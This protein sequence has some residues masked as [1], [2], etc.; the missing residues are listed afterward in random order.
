MSAA[1]LYTRYD[2]VRLGLAVGSER[3]AVMLAAAAKAK[4]VFAPGD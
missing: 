4:H 2:A 1:V 3:A